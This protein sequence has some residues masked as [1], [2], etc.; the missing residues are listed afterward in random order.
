VQPIIVHKSR[1]S[2]LYFVDLTISYLFIQNTMKSG[3]SLILYLVDIHIT[4]GVE[5][6][7]VKISSMIKIHQLSLFNKV[8]MPFVTFLT[9]GTTIGTT[10]VV[11]F[12]NHLS[13]S[14]ET[15]TSHW[16]GLL[17]ISRLWSRLRPRLKNTI[18]HTNPYLATLIIPFRIHVS[19]RSYWYTDIDHYVINTRMDHMYL[20]KCVKIM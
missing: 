8:K 20:V 10:R 13:I 3:K 11:N 9:L 17:G 16:G 4:S 7:W 2:Q 5:K 14:A 15:M 6:H 1:T 18:E 12:Y 19:E